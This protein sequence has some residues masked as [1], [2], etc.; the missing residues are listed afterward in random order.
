M[1][2]LRITFYPNTVGAS[3]E[4]L[5]SLPKYNSVQAEHGKSLLVDKAATFNAI[6]SLTAAGFN[7]HAISLGQSA[8]SIAGYQVEVNI[9]DCTTGHSFL[10]TND[11]PSASEIALQLLKIW[12]LERQC[13][14]KTIELFSLDNCDIDQA[15]LTFLIPF[16]SH[17][18]ANTAK[19]ALYQHAEAIYHHACLKSSRNDEPLG[20][21]GNAQEG[22][23]RLV[24]PQR[25]FCI[26][27]S[28]FLCGIKNN[29]PLKA[30]TAKKPCKAAL[31]SEAGKYLRLEVDLS[32]QWLVRHLLNTPLGWKQLDTKADT[33]VFRVIKDALWFD[34][35]FRQRRPRANQL[36]TK[37][38]DRELANWHFA[39]NDVR[40]HSLVR[41]S[42]NP[43]ETFL[44][45]NERIRKALH[46][47]YSI[48]WHVQ[49]TKVSH[50][51]ASLLAVKGQ[52]I[53]PQKLKSAIFGLDAAADAIA[54]LKSLIA[55]KTAGNKLT[56]CG[57]GQSAQVQPQEKQKC[58]DTAKIKRRNKTKR[59]SRS[60]NPDRQ[61]LFQLADK[62]DDSTTDVFEDFDEFIDDDDSIYCR[63]YGSHDSSFDDVDDDDE[64]SDY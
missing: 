12:L 6:S 18:E 1:E 47:D 36:P 22:T 53:P 35:E 31:S 63:S 14:P 41:G 57:T 30:K 51:L 15:T 16:A 28:T 52:Y 26:R 46:I 39:G 37:K 49:Q 8:S 9:G 21:F 50:Q 34:F 3:P 10:T 20:W 24:H 62:V 4:V 11:I 60:I 54:E 61:P 33:K 45:G 27:A 19:Q 42:K 40:E 23:W 17:V 64:I 25:H 29:K 43:S 48:P 44:A 58:P 32:K 38:M 2:N 7:V 59:A 56:R 13:H 5:A 55:G